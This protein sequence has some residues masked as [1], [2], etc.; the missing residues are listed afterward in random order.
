MNRAKASWNVYKLA[1]DCEM[2]NW[3]SHK[4]IKKL[5]KLSPVA[6]LLY[7][8]KVTSNQGDRYETNEK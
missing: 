8:N 6:R 4:K 3:I 2:S 7:S 1:N 5:V